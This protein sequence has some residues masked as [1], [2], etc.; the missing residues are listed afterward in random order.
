MPANYTVSQPTGLTAD[1]TQKDTTGSF[2][3]DDK[4]YDGTNAATVDTADG[5]REGRPATSCRL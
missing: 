4:V 3:A 5:R 1:I 2:T